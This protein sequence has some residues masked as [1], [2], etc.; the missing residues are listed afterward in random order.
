LS[1]QSWNEQDVEIAFPG[2]SSVF[3]VPP[4]HRGVCGSRTT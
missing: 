2:P 3:I 4:L 1:E